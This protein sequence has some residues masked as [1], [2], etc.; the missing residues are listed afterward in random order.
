[1]AKRI[2][3]VLTQDVSKLGRN[4][5]LVEVAPGYARNY[6]LPQG[7]AMNVTPGI[8]KQVERRRE[9]QRQR[10]LE[11]KQQA[12]TQR[13]A[14]EA[15]GRFTVAKQEGENEAIFGTV[16]NAEVA[17]A[18]QAQTGYEIDRR[19]ITLPE[20]HKLG[21]YKVEVK[22]YQDVVATITLDVVA[23]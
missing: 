9:I 20:I 15:I 2:Q 16:T 8:M 23:K 1:M 5:D 10:M 13:A 21:H 14:I 7:K 19:N 18:L 12:E 17:E 3:L 11:E 4:G 22:L 6:L